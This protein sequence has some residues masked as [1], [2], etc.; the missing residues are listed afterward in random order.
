MQYYSDYYWEDGKPYG[1]NPLGETPGRQKTA[2]RVVS[3]PYY[4]WISI[5]KYENGIFICSIYDTK[6]FDFRCLKPL[7]QIA[8]KKDAISSSDYRCMIKNQDDRIIALE[9]YAFAGERCRMCTTHSAHGIIIS[10]QKIYY[11]DFGDPFNGVALFD[12]NKRI[13]MYKRYSIDSEGA[14]LEVLEENWKM[15]TVTLLY[16]QA[17]I[18]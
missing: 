13:V 11:S 2:Y 1:Q 10:F 16:A 3:D 18:K 5:E 14:F 9:E 8:W 12:S 17:T 7:H 4:K 15:K 6:V